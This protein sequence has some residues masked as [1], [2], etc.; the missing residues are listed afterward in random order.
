MKFLL[1]S[2]TLFLCSIFSTSR[3]TRC[4]QVPIIRLI[5]ADTDSNKEKPLIDNFLFEA[6][7]KKEKKKERYA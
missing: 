6:K 5:K 7:G 4:Q 3:Q 1:L 2:F